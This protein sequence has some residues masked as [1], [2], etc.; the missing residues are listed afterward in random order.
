MIVTRPDTC[1]KRPSLCEKLMAGYAK[2][3]AYMHAHPKECIDILK[4]RMP[5]MDAAVLTESFQRILKWTPSSTRINE[6]V[7]PNSQDFMI[8]G[9]MLKTEEKL[10]SFKDI[11]T[12][13]FTR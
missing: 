8:A 2:A 5:G 10:T 6:A 12:N 3:A 4:K 9:G 11:Y 7:F 13:K 1:E